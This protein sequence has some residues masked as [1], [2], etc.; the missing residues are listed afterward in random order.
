MIMPRARFFLVPL[1]LYLSS[2]SIDRMPLV[3]RKRKIKRK[4]KE[5]ASAPVIPASTFPQFVRPPG[6]VVRLDGR[7]PLHFP[8]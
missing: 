2:G 6:F 1:S 8:A 7:F 4:E 5:L 3:G